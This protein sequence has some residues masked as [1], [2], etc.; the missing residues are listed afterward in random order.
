MDVSTM[1]QGVILLSI[2]L[3]LFLGSAILVMLYLKQGT[4]KP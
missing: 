1:V 3:S 2:K 4:Q